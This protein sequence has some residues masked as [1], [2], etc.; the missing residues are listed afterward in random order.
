[1]ATSAQL[2][3]SDVLEAVSERFPTGDATRESV[4]RAMLSEDEAD[5]IIV[6]RREVEESELPWEELRDEFDAVAN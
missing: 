1:M 6:K 3:E 5:M 4:L 2:T